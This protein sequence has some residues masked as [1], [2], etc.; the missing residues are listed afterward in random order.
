MDV[1]IYAPLSGEIV[2]IED[3]RD[4]VFRKIVGDGVAIRPTGNTIVTPVDGV[5]GK[6]LKPIMPFQMESKEALKLF[7]H[8]GIDT[9][10]AERRRVYRVV[11]KVK[12]LNVVM[13]LSNLIL[14]FW[15]QSKICIN[16]CCDLQY[17]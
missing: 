12:R 3:V 5:I 10:R 9:V 13:L 4:V 6:I 8:F 14:R 15:K 2:N 1:E 16:S 17:G 7:V 11:Q